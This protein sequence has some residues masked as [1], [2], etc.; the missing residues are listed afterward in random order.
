VTLDE[1]LDRAVR[2]LQA[3]GIPYMLTGSIASSIYGEPRST[4]DVDILIDPPA[5]ALERLV[6]RL[7][8][9]ELHVDPDAARAALLERGQFSALVLDSKVDFII[10]KDDPHAKVAFERRRHIRGKTIDAD[11]VSPEDLIL[12]KLLWARETGSER[13]LRDVAG[14]I[15]LAE[16]LDRGYIENWAERLGILDAWLRLRG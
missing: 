3:E 9:A 16:E 11:V 5:D 6:E 8:A 12:A 2:A 10:R 14:I 13:Q 1:L 15:A 7:Q 4:N